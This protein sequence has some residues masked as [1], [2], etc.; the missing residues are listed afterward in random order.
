M[1]FLLTLLFLISMMVDFCSI[2]TTVKN[3][4]VQSSYKP[5]ERIASYSP[6]IRFCLIIRFLTYF[7]YDVVFTNTQ[8]AFLRKYESLG[9]KVIF[10]A[11]K[12][13]WPDQSLEVRWDDYHIVLHKHDN[14]WRYYL[15]V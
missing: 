3:L 8:E 6:K 11:E 5:T 9:H 12:S 2:T 14:I 13:C 15:L 7:S 4:A 1:I 10:S